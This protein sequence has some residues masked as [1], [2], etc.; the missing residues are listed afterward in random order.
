MKL[1]ARNSVASRASPTN[2][3]ILTEGSI[4]AID[5]LCQT[6]SV[7]D[8]AARNS[9]VKANTK[10]EVEKQMRNLS[11][12]LSTLDWGVVTTLFAL[13][14]Y[15]FVTCEFALGISTLTSALSASIRIL[16]DHF[17]KTK[18]K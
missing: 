7:L 4:T 1:T 10:D 11:I 8:E 12:A 6:G 17:N 13:S 3:C 15:H 14:I 2:K 5:Q 18:A 16:R 9:A